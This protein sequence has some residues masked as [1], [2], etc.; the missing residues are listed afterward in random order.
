MRKVI[1]GLYMSLDGVASAPDGWQFPYLDT[2][3]IADIASSTSQVD[4]LLFGRRTYDEFSMLWPG[5][6][7]NH[8]ADFFN[9]THKY[10]VT[11]KTAGLDWGPVT[12]LNGDLAAQLAKLKAEPGK[13]ILIQGSIALVHSLLRGGLLDELSLLI[14]PI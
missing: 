4:T 5:Q 12:Q 8:S 1:A 11:S 13:D 9:S 7:G 14:I 3:V 10:V 2:E 6:R